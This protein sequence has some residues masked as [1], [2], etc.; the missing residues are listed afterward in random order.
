MNPFVM[1]QETQDNLRRLY[2]ETTL[3]KVTT[4]VAVFHVLAALGGCAEY[5]A[6]ELL[7]RAAGDDMREYKGKAYR[8]LFENGVPPRARR[9]ELEAH[10]NHLSEDAIRRYRLRQDGFAEDRWVVAVADFLE[11]LLLL[12]TL[13]LLS[14]PLIR[15]DQRGRIFIK[16]RIK[17]K[18]LK[19]H[20][21]NT[22]SRSAV[23]L[24]ASA[25]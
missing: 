5:Q 18:G 20:H 13:S 2:N 19:L 10:R 3:P 22:L 9:Y 15:C 8:C 7:L 4:T 1:N 25:S 23:W 6:H 11:R 12:L 17:K 16:T 21:D 24:H 14:L